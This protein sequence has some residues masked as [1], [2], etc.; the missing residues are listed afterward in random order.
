L[1]CI[2][3]IDGEVVRYVHLARALGDRQPVYG[4]RARGLDDGQQPFDDIEAMS[5]HYVAQMRAVWSGPFQVAGFSSGGAIALEVANQ[6]RDLGEQVSLVAMFDTPSFWGR[7]N[8]AAQ[9]RGLPYDLRAYVGHA[10]RPDQRLRFLREQGPSL[11][12]LLAWVTGA[13]RAL[14]HRQRLEALVSGIADE[15]APHHEVARAQLRA[16]ASHVPRPFDGRLVLFRARVRPLLSPHDPT[17]GWREFA[18]GGI[19]VIPVPG[20]HG[21]MFDEPYVGEL[22]R[23]LA[24]RLGSVSASRP[25]RERL[26]QQD[27]HAHPAQ[28]GADHQQSV[29]LERGVQQTAATGANDHANREGD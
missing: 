16:L 27:G 14:P 23:H 3:P 29:E 19:E 1:F 20:E 22:T 15:S 25:S 17:L 5:A 8:A 10:L 26:D 4:L 12:R 9:L 24:R 18:R 28:D 7:R 21:T 13:R 2:H 11:A 6:L